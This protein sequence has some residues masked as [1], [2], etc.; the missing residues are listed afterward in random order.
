MIENVWQHRMCSGRDRRIT[1]DPRYLL[2]YV[3][4][5]SQAAAMTPKPGLPSLFQQL[6]TTPWCRSGVLDSLIK[7]ISF[8]V[9]LVLTYQPYTI[10]IA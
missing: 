4:L 6:Q 1:P 2:R 5:S 3:K 9:G 8:T 7:Y 10:H